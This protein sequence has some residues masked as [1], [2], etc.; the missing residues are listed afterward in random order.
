MKDFIKKIIGEK[1]IHKIKNKI[2]EREELNRQKSEII[3]RADFYSQFVS[4]NDLCFDVGANIGNRVEPLLKLGAKVVAIEPQ[5]SCYL[6]LEKKFGH[7]I[8]IVTEGVGAEESEKDFHISNANTIS[9]FS[10]DWIK[11]VKDGRFKEYNWNKTVKTKITT[12]D[13]IIK[14]FGTPVF[15]K[16]DVEGYELEVLKGLS[17]IIKYISFEY[18]VPEQTTKALNCIKRLESLNKSVEF[19]YSVG[20]SMKLENS[21]W[22]NVED[23]CNLVQ[24]KDFLNTEFGDIYVRNQ[25]AKSIE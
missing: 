12:L 6:I 25:L 9:S 3:K 2:R 4:K 11:S 24:S 19:N 5:E 23:M 22:Y 14:K 1:N 13:N 10:E 7:K 21:I 15:I 16:I 8:T 18:T 17:S 20:E